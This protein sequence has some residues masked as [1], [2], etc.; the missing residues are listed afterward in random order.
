MFLQA[1]VILF[2]GGHVWPGGL[3]GWMGAWPGACVAEGC[4]GLGVVWLGA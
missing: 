4:A 1:C 2:T 3:H